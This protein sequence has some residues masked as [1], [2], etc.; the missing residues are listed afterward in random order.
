MADENELYELQQR[1]ARLPLGDRLLLV[2]SIVAEVRKQ[3]FTD[4]FR[5]R[6]LRVREGTT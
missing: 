2:E 3:N 4:R 5:S 6:V 1:V